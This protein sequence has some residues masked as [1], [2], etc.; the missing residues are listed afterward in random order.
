MWAEAPVSVFQCIA[1]GLG[2]EDEDWRAEAE[3]AETMATPAE[4][5]TPSFGQ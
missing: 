4:W 1:A 5:Q 3:L 2:S